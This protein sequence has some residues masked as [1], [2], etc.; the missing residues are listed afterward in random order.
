[1]ENYNIKPVRVEELTNSL[2]GVVTPYQQK[3]MKADKDGFDL[4]SILDDEI[5]KNKFPRYTFPQIEKTSDGT[6]FIV[7]TK[8]V[9]STTDNFYVKWLILDEKYQPVSNH[10]YPMVPLP[11][12]GYLM[13][14]MLYVTSPNPTDYAIVYLE[15]FHNIHVQSILS[16]NGMSQVQSSQ[17]ENQS[18]I[19]ANEDDKMMIQP[20]DL[21]HHP[22]IT[23]LLSDRSEFF[24]KYLSDMID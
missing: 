8:H 9:I 4:M 16:M 10:N 20:F 14:V 2:K 21:S 18:F 6:C 11:K 12:K 7:P 23:T 19:Q 22:G 3:Y 24:K 17:V 5:L 1:M 13:K 15:D